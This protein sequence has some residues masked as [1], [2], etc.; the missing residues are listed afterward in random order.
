MTVSQPPRGHIKIARKA[1]DSQHGDPLWLEP[2][3]FSRWEAWEDL[4]QLAT[5]QERTVS[6]KYGD[7]PL[8]R[9][10]VLTAV[11]HLAS[12]WR[13][14]KDAVT[15]F[16][17]FLVR[18]GRI[19]PA[20]LGRDA[21]SNQNPDARRDA[22]AGRFGTV[23][24]LVNY[25]TY[26]AEGTGSP[27]HRR[28]AKRDAKRDA[29]GDKKESSSTVVNPIMDEFDGRIWPFYPKRAGSNPRKAA[30][31][32]YS[33]RRGEGVSFDALADGLGRY[34]GYC[35]AKGWENTEFVMQA[36]RFF[37]PGREYENSWDVG[38]LKAG[39]K[40]PLQELEELGAQ[41]SW[42]TEGLEAAR[43]KRAA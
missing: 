12:R 24:L 11:R 20:P 9:G 36:K 21:I 3:Q 17:N 34:I 7:V 35:E 41:D 13:W 19:I 10:E 32:A 15:T 23:Y 14:R 43:R 5:Y 22:K 18:D 33:A 30:A 38:Q 28:D 26:Q 6:T 42:W 16:L 2:R 1:Y 37:G 31:D 39:E 8:G 4:I 29:S 40:S 27:T 25:D